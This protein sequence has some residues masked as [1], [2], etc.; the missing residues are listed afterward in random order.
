MAVWADD[1]EPSYLAVLLRG[2]GIEVEVRRLS[3]GDYQ[4]ESPLGRVGVE[5][6]TVDD[7]L[8][9]IASGRLD[10]E[11]ARLV[12]AV[13]LPVLFLQGGLEYFRGRPVGG[14]FQA[15]P[16]D[17]TAVLNK[18]LSWQLRGVAL[19]P[20]P[21]DGREGIFL[22]GLYRWT[23]KERHQGVARRPRLLPNMER[24]PPRVE[25]FAAL[26]GVGPERARLL[27][28]RASLREAFGGWSE[29][30][31]AAVVGPRRA[32]RIIH[33]LEEKDNTP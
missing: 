21:D 16:L 24:L 13:A 10:D 19:Y 5:R 17:L 15:V 14:G 33:L 18:L 9:S 31:W 3:A 23:Q 12:E 25:V 22:A 26:P 28:A 8:S 27:A 7:L 32:A 4:W 6:K 20:L 1:R 11:L 30:D 29:A 2:E